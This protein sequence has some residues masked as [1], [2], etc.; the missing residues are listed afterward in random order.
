MAEKK[1]KKR[2]VVKSWKKFV[3]LTKKYQ[4]E[5]IAATIVY[6]SS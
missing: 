5:R 2:I 3:R 4:K 6:K 1:E